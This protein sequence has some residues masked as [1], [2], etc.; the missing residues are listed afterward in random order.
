L[1]NY[2]ILIVEDEVLIAEDIRISL[3]ELGYDISDICYDSENAMD[4]I[5]KSRP[6]MVILDINIRGSKNGIEIAE[7]IN[8][9]YQI[10]FI[11]LTSLSDR[12]TLEKAKKT[13]PKGY[14]TKPFKDKDLL[15]TI[16]MAIYNHSQEMNQKNITK[17]HVDAVA[18]PNLSDKEYEVLLDII[19]GCN[20]SQIASNH[21]ISINTVKTH[22]KRIFQ[23]INVTDR[24]TLVKKI[25][26]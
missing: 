16:E 3:N 6:D 14:L 13:R 4:S 10:P 5:Y 21:F 26:S 19:S 24:V 12:D 17:V 22:V 11:F 18:Q 20:N 7:I 15:T 23:K 8:E 9:K 2:R 25:L 1:E